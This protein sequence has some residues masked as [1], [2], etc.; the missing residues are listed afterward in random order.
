VSW[1]KRDNIFTKK[2]KLEKWYAPTVL[3]RNDR[4][5]LWLSLFLLMSLSRQEK[6]RADKKKMNK[7]PQE[8]SN[9][10]GLKKLPICNPNACDIDCSYKTFGKENQSHEYDEILKKYALIS[11]VEKTED[12]DD[13]SSTIEVFS[14]VFC[15]PDAMY[16][17]ENDVMD[18]MGKFFKEINIEYDEWG[19][20]LGFFS[21]T[22]F[23]DSDLE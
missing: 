8:S 13:N 7:P 17:Y 16:D 18:Q 9:F 19:G 23:I 12:D 10:Q 3:K 22:A 15:P 6:R 11:H 21:A 14:K 1:I 4:I 2:H 5:D 20:G